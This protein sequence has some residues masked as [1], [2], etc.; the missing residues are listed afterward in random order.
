M[1]PLYDLALSSGSQGTGIIASPP[2]PVPSPRTQHRAPRKVTFLSKQSFRKTKAADAF[3]GSLGDALTLPDATL[4]TPASETV[5]KPGDG[6][7]PETFIVGSFSDRGTSFSDNDPPVVPRPTAP[8]QM[9]RRRG[10][11][12]KKAVQTDS[13]KFARAVVL[14]KYRHDRRKGSKWGAVA[15]AMR[16]LAERPSIGTLTTGATDDELKNAAEAMRDWAMKLASS[17]VVQT[18]GTANAR[19]K[20]S[21]AESGNLS[22]YS[23]DEVV[24]RLSLKKSDAV[25]EGINLLWAVLPKASTQRVAI[26]KETYVKVFG[27]VAEKILGEKITRKQLLVDWEYDMSRGRGEGAGMSKEAF[28]SAT[29]DMIDTW[30]ASTAEQLYADTGRRCAEAVYQECYPDAWQVLPEGVPDVPAN[31]RN[32]ALLDVQAL[33][34]AANEVVPTTVVHLPEAGECL[35]DLE[36]R[37][38]RGIDESGAT[39]R[40]RCTHYHDPDPVVVTEKPEV[41]TPEMKALVLI[42][43]VRHAADVLGPESPDVVSVSSSVGGFNDLGQSSDGARPSTGGSAPPGKPRPAYDVSAAQRAAILAARQRYEAQRM[44][45]S[46]LRPA[47]FDL[48]ILPSGGSDAA[49]VVPREM[50]MPGARP[51]SGAP[52]IPPPVPLSVPGLPCADGTPAPRS[53]TPLV[54]AV[55]EQPPLEEALCAPLP[56]TPPVPALAAA[57]PPPGRS[58]ALALASTGRL[59]VVQVGADLATPSPRVRAPQKPTERGEVVSTRWLAHSP[60]KLCCSVR[61]VEAE[62]KAQGLVK[63]MPAELRRLCKSTH[64]DW[65]TMSWVER[66]RVVRKF[67]NAFE[68]VQAQDQ[69]AHQQSSGDVVPP[70]GDVLPYFASVPALPTAPPPLLPAAVVGGG[71]V[72]D[73]RPDGMELRLQRLHSVIAPLPSPRHEEQRGRRVVP[74]PPRTPAATSRASSA[75]RSTRPP[76]PTA[77][78]TFLRFESDAR[79]GATR[80]GVVGVLCAVAAAADVPGAL[81]LCVATPQTPEMQLGRRK[82]SV[83]PGWSPFA[84]GR[85]IKDRGTVV[86]AP[87]AP[88]AL[89]EPTPPVMALDAPPL[90]VGF[91]RAPQNP[92]VPPYWLVLNKRPPFPTDRA[93]HPKVYACEAG[94]ETLYESILQPQPPQPATARGPRVQHVDDLIPRLPFGPRG[95]AYRKCTVLPG[96]R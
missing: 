46:G 6:F 17:G 27:C 22:M 86:K 69:Q 57:T 34:A 87:A 14:T 67:K 18:H 37:T 50:P 13:A 73:P 82:S 61:H 83:K 8:Q 68:L 79:R 3:T 65:G 78:L 60:T 39:G 24:K 32:V 70:L 35:V 63:A 58:S 76:S 72:V 90:K 47:H 55:P 1:D 94:H 77:F 4:A 96:R 20:T 16:H 95:K 38:W 89:T 59:S 75:S 12:E 23:R 31:W 15:K 56:P 25:M 29:F 64:P 74:A 81:S 92:D 21:H 53:D 2:A 62:D 80:A 42:P 52:P 33:E 93:L 45:A 36:R 84:G 91:I 26:T 9:A 40:I 71:P 43:S 7:T 19:R 88:S 5:P 51:P 48:A 11:K 30:T 44:A 49:S 66:W 85:E 54:A 28:V 10:S 41:K